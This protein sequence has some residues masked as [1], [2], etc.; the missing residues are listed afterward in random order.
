MTPSLLTQPDAWAPLAIIDAPMHDTNG[1]VGI[2]SEADIVTA[3]Q[4]GRTLAARLGFSLT[5]STLVATA[6]SELARNILLYAGTGT[7]VLQSIDDAARRGIL[8]VASDHGPGIV[9]V[10]QALAGGYST[11]GGLGLGLCGVRGLVDDFDLVSDVGAGTTV[12]LR[13]WIH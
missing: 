13:K 11:S 7:I 2:L 6:I 4:Q 5:E 9:D 10:R 1:I 12:T 3:R 8:I